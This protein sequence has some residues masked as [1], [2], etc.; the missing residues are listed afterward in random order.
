MRTTAAIARAIIRRSTSVLYIPVTERG[1]SHRV[2]KGRTRVTRPQRLAVGDRVPLHGGSVKD[3]GD[4]RKWI[5]DVAATI[6]LLSVD[7]I[8]LGHL[9][10]EQAQRAGFDTAEEFEQAWVRHHDQEWLERQIEALLEAGVDR[11]EAEET[12]DCWATVRYRDRWASRVVWMLTVQPAHDVDYV[13]APAGSTAAAHSELGYV[14]GEDVL[15][16]GVAQPVGQL[17]ERWAR[18]SARRHLDALVGEQS[19]RER[20]VRARQ[21][22]RRVRALALQDPSLVREIER[23]VRDAEQEAA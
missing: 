17:G 1:Y 13:M 15:G 14:V 21:L 20:A 8:V 22:S 12:E 9:T 6:E 7:R 10:S 18:K 4:E 23:L 5:T 3:I 16:G 11:E 19:P 2:S